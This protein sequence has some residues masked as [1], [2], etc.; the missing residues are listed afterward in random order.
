MAEA[1]SILKALTIEHG[2]AMKAAGNPTF[3]PYPVD[4]EEAQAKA[5]AALAKELAENKKTAEIE[6]HYELKAE[7]NGDTLSA[8]K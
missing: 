6:Q 8:A 7:A 4:E 2:R 3:L 5:A 1:L